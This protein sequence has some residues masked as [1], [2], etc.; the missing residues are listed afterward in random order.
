M[1]EFHRFP[2]AAPPDFRPLYISQ[3]QFSD[4]SH[5]PTWYR[6]TLS[7]EHGVYVMLLMSFLTGAA[8]QQ[9]TLATS[10]ALVCAFAG[11]QAE[12]RLVL[13][14]K[15]RCSLKPRFV[16]WGSIYAGLSLGMAAYLYWQVSLL[17]CA[18]ISR[19]WHWN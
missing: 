1:S 16:L 6:P 10:L 8:A 4:V 14:I 17:L 19:L 2:N 13:Q 3:P 5:T 12:H 18:I 11:F 15:Q 7:H 9:W